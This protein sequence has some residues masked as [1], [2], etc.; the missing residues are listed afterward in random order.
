MAYGA[1]LPTEGTGLASEAPS[2]FVTVMV[3]DVCRG[4]GSF[5]GHCYWLKALS[6]SVPAHGILYSKM[7]SYQ[8]VLTPLARS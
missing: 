3:G 5:P 2:S 7:G 4:K 8:A 1:Y 6:S